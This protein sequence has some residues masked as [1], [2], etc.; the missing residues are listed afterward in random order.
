MGKG[1]IPNYLE[2]SE[3]RKEKKREGIRALMKI[4]CENMELENKYWLKE[5][6]RKCI[7]CET[8]KDNLI[9]FT[10]NCEITKG[11]FEG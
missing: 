7:F 1:R 10:G 9:H 4:R 5:E 3:L 11:W 6:E 2:E 8:E